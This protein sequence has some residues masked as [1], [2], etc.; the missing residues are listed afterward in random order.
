MMAQLEEKQGDFDAAKLAFTAG[1]KFCKNKTPLWINFALLEEKTGNS[2]RARALLEHG[3]FE[4]PKCVDIWIASIRFEIRSANLKA[5]EVI[6]ASAFQKFPQ[7]GLLWSQAIDMAPS[8]RRKRKCTEAMKKCNN[9]PHIIYAAAKIFLIDRKVSKARNWILR[10]VAIC[11]KVGDFWAFLYCI[12][13]K[14]RFN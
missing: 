11:P 9:D 5:A 6:L 8:S 1:L 10:G 3:L 12:E 14:T 2:I 7:S 4:N 13:K